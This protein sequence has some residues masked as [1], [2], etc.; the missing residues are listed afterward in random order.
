MA[1]YPR[2]AMERART[3]QAVIFKAIGG[4]LHW[5][6]AVAILRGS[7]PTLCRWKPRSER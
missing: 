3:L 2:P 5:L 1:L 7:A 6:Q 4:Q